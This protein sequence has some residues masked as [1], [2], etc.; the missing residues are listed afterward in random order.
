MVRFYG[1]LFSTDALYTI[2]YC[3]MAAPSR[4]VPN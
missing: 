1:S 4:K 2:A 3:V